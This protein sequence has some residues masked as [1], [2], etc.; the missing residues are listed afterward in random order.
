VR[1]GL[2][3]PLEVGQGDHRVH[4][5]SSKQRALIALLALDAGQVVSIDRLIDGLWGD[6]APGDAL[7]ALRHHV[8]RLRKTI[9]PSLVTRISGYLL[10]VRQED[11]DALVFARLIGEARAGL[12]DGRHGQVAA[13]LGS[14]LAL[15]RGAPL[16]E[17]VDHDWARQAASRLEELRLTAVEDRF[18]V[19][20]A[21]GL[22]ADVVQELRGEVSAHPFRE[23]LWGLGSPAGAGAGPVEAAGRRPAGPPDQLHRPARAAGGH[24]TVAEGAPADHPHRAARR[25]QDP[26]LCGGRPAG[27][28]RVC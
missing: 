20:L 4:L 26:P 28:A 17:F 13:T 11:V 24:P 1:V 14:A 18:E 23:R 8:S 9:G 5:A 2:L 22:H 6:D 7:N 3:G 19:D 12:R 10:E 15:W 27:P 16:E 21:M 25:G